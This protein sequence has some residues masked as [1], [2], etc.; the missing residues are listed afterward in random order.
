MRHQP[1]AAPSAFDTGAYTQE[2][3]L[4]AT[5]TDHVKAYA[6]KHGIKYGEAL[7]LASPSW[8]GQQKGGKYGK[9]S[10]KRYMKY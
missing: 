5:W 8:H 7:K 1:L 6:A 10:P 3:R 4:G 9:R 2:G